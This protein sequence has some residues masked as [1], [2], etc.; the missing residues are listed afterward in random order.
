M[1]YIFCQDTKAGRLLPAGVCLSDPQSV[2]L[3][4]TFEVSVS[5][6]LVQGQCYTIENAKFASW[7]PI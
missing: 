3:A 7:T 6:S 5:R 1:T 4:K 2:C